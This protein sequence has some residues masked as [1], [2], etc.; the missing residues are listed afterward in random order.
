M[1]KLIIEKELRDIIGS[2]KF[3]VSFAVCAVLILL[4][5][6]VGAKNHQ[7]NIARY[8]AA[9]AENLRKMEGLT[10]W[11]RVSSHRIFLPPQPLESLVSGVS[12][13]IGR[14]IEMIGRGELSS[15]DSRFSQDPIFA[16]FRFLDLEF[17]FQIIL[18]LFAILF[19]FDAING[20]KERGTLQLAFANKVPRDKFIMGKLLGSF[21]AIGVPLLI[22]I[23]L[24]CLLLP[25]FKVSLS[26]DEYMRLGAVIFTG[27]LYFCAF[28]TLSVF[29][30]SLTQKT[31][32]SFLMLLVI[33]IF[34]V[35]IIPR[36][37]VLLA[38][39]AVDVPSVDELSYQK[40]RYRAQ[41]W[42]EDG[43]RMSEFKPSTT[44]DMEKMVEEF[45]KFMKELSDERNRKIEEYNDRLN[46]SRTSKQL[47]Q[48]RLAFTFA[49]L[50]P[51]AVFSL[52]STGLVGTSIAQ[53]Q[54][55]LDEAAGYQQSYAS[56]MKEKTGRTPGGDMILITMSSDDEEEE[57]IDPSELPSFEYNA[58]PFAL[59]LNATLLDIALLLLY[60]LIFFIGAFV[61]FIRYDVR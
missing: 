46:E 8:Q 31:S 40:S 15:V 35:L 13:D 50:S 2:T 22:P 16:V 41:L 26:G 20:E 34:A 49:R 19:A 28:L 4:T 7:L 43:K 27:L 56:F 24:G 60:N 36:S 6:Y 23:I 33:W 55:F 21:I 18:S 5:F 30:S 51:S 45:N 9:K 12:N 39:R 58:A 10:D 11:M 48:E 14:T 29:I 47:A 42:K 25:V 32:S 61:G 17:I 3:A 54:H 57:P 44:G 1:I 37:A 53:K 52:A 59:A 38:G